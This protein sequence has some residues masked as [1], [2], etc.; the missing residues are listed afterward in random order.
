MSITVYKSELDAGLGEAVKKSQSIAYNS[1]AK[2]ANN[3]GFNKQD[4]SFANNRINLQDEDLSFLDAILVSVGLNAN[5]DCFLAEEVWQARNSSVHKQFNYMHNQRD[6]IGHIFASNVFDIDSNLIADDTVFDDVPSFFDIV[7]SAVLYVAWPQDDLQERMDNIISGIA[8]GKWFVSME[9]LFKNFDYALSDT[10]GLQIVTRNKS[11]AFLTKYLRAFGGSGEY[12]GQKIS[13]VLRKFSF[14]GKGLVDNPA[15]ERSIIFDNIERLKSYSIAFKGEETKMSEK[16]T[17]S[18]ELKTAVI[19]NGLDVAS[20]LAQAQTENTNLRKELEDKSKAEL[21]SAKAKFD[22]DLAASVAFLAKKDEEITV[23]KT[24]V[25][26]AISQAKAA[27]EKFIASQ[28]ELDVMKTENLKQTRINKLVQAGVKEGVNDIVTKWL[29]ASEEQ[30]D[31]IVTLY[32][33][34]V[35]KTPEE[36]AEDKKK[37]EEDAEDADEA[38]EAAAKII[39]DNKVEA[40]KT[41]TMA[42]NTSVEEDDKRLVAAASAWLSGVLN[43]KTETK[44]E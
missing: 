30:F 4:F 41:A 15:N 14:N 16:I 7:S 29:T 39:E 37:K 40:E 6:I 34:K 43:Q 26:D 44:G 32:G 24:Q 19:N 31:E 1:I 36:K 12:N 27:K 23:L 3:S 11:T 18:M 8:L 28:A 2:L 13:R 38:A 10:S 25:D 9:C 20:M 35:T 17:E 33:A 22:A 21:T 5:D 42:S